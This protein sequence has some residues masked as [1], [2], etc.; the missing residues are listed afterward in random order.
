MQNIWIF[1]E[2]IAMTDVERTICRCAIEFNPRMLPA[3]LRRPLAIYQVDIDG[4]EPVWLCID[5]L[6]GLEEW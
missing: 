3:H 4:P 6:I 5:C 2:G 1:K